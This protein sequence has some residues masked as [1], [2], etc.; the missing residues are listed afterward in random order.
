MVVS[1]YNECFDQLI[2]EWKSFA[3]WKHPKKSIGAL[4]IVNIVW[5]YLKTTECTNLNL[6]LW[7]I[8]MVYIYKCVIAHI[9]MEARSPY[10]PKK[11]NPIVQKNQS[12]FISDLISEAVDE[13]IKVHEISIS[14]ISFFVEDTKT[15]LTVLCDLRKDSPGMFCLFLSSFF[16]LACYYGSFL[17]TTTLVY[18]FTMTSLLLPIITK[19]LMKRLP[20][21]LPLLRV[22]GTRLRQAASEITKKINSTANVKLNLVKSILH[23]RMTKCPW[24]S[25][26]FGLNQENSTMDNK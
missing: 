9:W 22:F 11:Q 26:N 7:M 4:L 21:R 8:M 2:A 5:T 1:T 12:E 14:E 6:A 23:S 3:S 17:S 18:L 13:E 25:R 20:E 10:Q 15:Y 24:Y 16:F 19:H